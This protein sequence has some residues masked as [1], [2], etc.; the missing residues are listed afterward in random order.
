MTVAPGRP[1]PE[2]STEP[3]ATC[4]VDSANPSC[5]EL[6]M[7]AVL[8]VSAANPWRGTM[9]MIFEHPLES[10]HAH[11]DALGIVEPVDADRKLFAV[12]AAAQP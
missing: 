5:A 6:R 3:V 9:R 8:A 10:L 4:V 2:P 12:E 7:I 1:R 11:G